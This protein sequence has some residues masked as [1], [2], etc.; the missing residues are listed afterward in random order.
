MIIRKVE[1]E[2]YGA[3]NFCNRGS[4]NQSKT[5]IDYPYKLVAQLLATGLIVNICEEC[6][7]ILKQFK[8]SE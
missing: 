5:G 2:H 3:C 4:L 7:N 6:L 1:V 8:L